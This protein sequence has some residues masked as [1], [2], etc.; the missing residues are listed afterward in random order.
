MFYL[1][2]QKKNEVW[3][4]LNWTDKKCCVRCL[5]QERNTWKEIALWS[6]IKAFTTFTAISWIGMVK[7]FIW[8]EIISYTNP[9]LI[10]TVSK[11]YQSYCS[12]FMKQ[13]FSISSAIS[14]W[15]IFSACEKEMVVLKT[16]TIRNKWE[17]IKCLWVKNE[18]GQILIYWFLS[19]AFHFY[20][21]TQR[22]ASRKSTSSI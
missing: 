9:H 1:W 7:V 12:H 11:F 22:S 10:F 19:E 16:C 20:S 5:N 8:V 14:S 3:T 2:K 4:Y 15:K 18:I 17:W 21:T 6:D 13:I